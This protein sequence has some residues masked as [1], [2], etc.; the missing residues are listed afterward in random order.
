M[1]TK[2]IVL[3]LPAALLGLLGSGF[4]NAEDYPET[5]RTLQ[6]AEGCVFMTTLGT[7]S[8]KGCSVYKSARNTAQNEDV[9]KRFGNNSGEEFL[10]FLQTRESLVVNND[11]GWKQW[12]DNMSS[13]IL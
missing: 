12:Y 5:T 6:P 3:R 4:M 7:Q 1:K 11:K 2:L 9:L 13:R 10:S 8:S